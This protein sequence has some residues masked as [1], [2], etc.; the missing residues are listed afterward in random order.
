MVAWVNDANAMGTSSSDLEVRNR[1]VGA[2][3]PGDAYKWCVRTNGRW[4]RPDDSGDGKAERW[5]GLDSAR[6]LQVFS[7]EEGACMG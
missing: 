2:G 6:L 4:R 3:G 7:D 5:H 1:F